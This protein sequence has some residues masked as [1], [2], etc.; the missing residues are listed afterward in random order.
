VGLAPYPNT[1]AVDT[2]YNINPNTYYNV[3]TD[4]YGRASLNYNGIQISN[5]IPSGDGSYNTGRFLDSY[6]VSYTFYDFYAN[7]NK[8][9]ISYNNGN[10]PSSFTFTVSSLGSSNGIVSLLLVGGGGAGAGGNAVQNISGLV[11]TG[12][13]GASGG[14]V[15]I[16]DNFKLE[17][18]I[19]YT[20]TIGPG[21]QSSI[22]SY[23]S[24]VNSP[25]FDGS[26]TTFS[27][28]NGGLFTAAGGKGGQIDYSN[29]ASA[30]NGA[31]G[32][33]VYPILNANSLT[34][35]G[36]GGVVTANGTSVTGIN[37]SGIGKSITYGSAITPY[38]NKNSPAFT[39]NYY[40]GPVIWSY[41][42]NG[43]NCDGS[44][45]AGGGGGAGGPGSDGFYNP[46]TTYNIGGNGG[47]EL[48]VYFTTSNTPVTTT[49]NSVVSGIGGG[50]GGW[51]LFT[52]LYQAG[53]SGGNNTGVS[54]TTNGTAGKPGTGCA[55]GNGT[56]SPGSYGGT[57]GSG[58][59][60]IRFQSY[61]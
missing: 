23:G 38:V 19:I 6:N 3:R 33:S 35:S 24:I 18:G 17:L 13:S 51:G 52:G 34:S 7:P 26:Q 25:G 4:G 12:T 40:P 29:G 48:F 30:F 1:P 57:G 45:N 27:D 54:N 55:G 36:G 31:P 9:S 10:G 50:A 42:N 44:G 43:G 60:I 14:E 16:V 39:P 21:G 20:V 46:S 56:P 37:P 49:D 11:P 5:I 41:G 28:A 61:S 58:R 32:T 47:S 53:S 2:C 22:G 59:F 8:N 15:L